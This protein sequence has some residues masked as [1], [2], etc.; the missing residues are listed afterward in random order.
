[1]FILPKGDRNNKITKVMKSIKVNDGQAIGLSKP[2]QILNTSKC[3]V[4]LPD[5][6]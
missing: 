3:I 1:M 6:T 2:N 5:V 4:D